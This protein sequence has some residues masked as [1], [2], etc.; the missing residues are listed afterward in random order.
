MNKIDSAN[1]ERILNYIA[2]LPGKASFQMVKLDNGAWHLHI[3]DTE[4]IFE[5]MGSNLSMALQKICR[6]ID[7]HG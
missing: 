1:I 2:A 5:E 4:S 7:V 3:T 6:L